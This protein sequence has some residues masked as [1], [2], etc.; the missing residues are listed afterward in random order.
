MHPEDHKLKEGI[1]TGDHSAFHLLFTRLWPGLVRYASSITR[2]EEAARELIQDLFLDLWTHRATIHIRGSIRTY[3]FTATYNRSINWLRHKKVR[4]LYA[5]NPVEIHHWLP[6]A[7]ALDSNDP[8][9]ADEISKAIQELPQRSRETFTRQ[10][11]LGE[12][13]ASIAKA[14]GITVKTVENQVARAR[15]TL[16]AKLKK[17]LP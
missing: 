8:L 2:D 12:S 14:L 7:E 15:K 6:S 1:R 9:L 10:V 17:Y 4:E 13:Q 11:I 16:Q 5:H 3:L